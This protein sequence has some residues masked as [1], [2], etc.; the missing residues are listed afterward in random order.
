[1]ARIRWAWA[2]AALAGLSAGCDGGG[3]SAEPK[4]NGPPHP[5]LAPSG[6]NTGGEGG[7]TPQPAGGGFKRR[8]T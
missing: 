7:G 5:E 3:K 1:M 8:G 2:L 4:Y 6:A